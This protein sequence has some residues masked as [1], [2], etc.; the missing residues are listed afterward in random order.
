MLQGNTNSSQE[1]PS[2]T[3]ADS[4]EKLHLP[5]QISDETMIV[6]TTT[7]RDKNVGITY[8]EIQITFGKA[9]PQSQTTLRANRDQNMMGVIMSS[10]LVRIRFTSSAG[11]VACLGGFLNVF[12]VFWACLLHRRLSV[13][14]KLRWGLLSL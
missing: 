6:E 5:K 12:C 13:F 4:N 10:M 1:T 8:N 14:G 11:L 9:E 3:N 7:T 2:E